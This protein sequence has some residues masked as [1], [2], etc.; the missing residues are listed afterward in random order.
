MFDFDGVI[1]DSLSF[2]HE[3][4]AACCA[5]EG[6]ETVRELE[7][8]LDLFDA[9]MVKGLMD[10]GIAADRVSGV[11]TDLA[12]RLAAEPERYPPFDGIREALERLTAQAPV[13]II[14]SNVSSVV[15]S[16]LKRFGI[17]GVRDVLGADQEPS[18]RIKIETL[19]AQWPE[20]LPVYIGDTLGDMV[21]S[22]AASARPIGVAWGWHGAERLQRGDPHAVLH[23]PA[24]LATLTVTA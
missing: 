19:K 10:I 6:C 4:L 1:A 5:Q 3:S 15:R 20:L 12:V 7:V 8:F 21:E 16:Y 11:L 2:F 13:Y 17:E 18:K 14:T 24:E 22:H 9:N 23:A